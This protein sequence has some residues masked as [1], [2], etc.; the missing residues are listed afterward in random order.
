MW[1]R[2]DSAVTL[3]LQIGDTRATAT[4]A[5][6]AG[7]RRRLADPR[8][9]PRQ[10]VGGGW[11]PVSR[12]DS[13]V[14]Y[15]WELESGSELRVLTLIASATEIVCA[16]GYRTALVGRSHECDYPADVKSLPQVTAPR[17]NPGE[18]S[19]RIDE[20]V[21]GTRAESDFA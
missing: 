11:K 17:F 15:T 1:R 8:L 5:P 16:L 9:G 7:P 6:V 2:G 18:S 20:Q 14:A 12:S 4:P 3:Q 21:K 13:T 19:R 10:Q